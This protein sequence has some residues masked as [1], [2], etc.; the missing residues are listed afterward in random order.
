M[1]FEAKQGSLILHCI[2]TGDLKTFRKELQSNIEK[3]A[4]GRTCQWHSGWEFTNAEKS[5]DQNGT[6]QLSL[7]G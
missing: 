2:L 4:P 7:K 5:P 6:L 3:K 1:I